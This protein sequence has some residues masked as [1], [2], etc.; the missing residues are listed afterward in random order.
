MTDP[1]DSWE[2]PELGTSQ[3]RL[4]AF[5]VGS[6]CATALVAF[7]VTLRAYRRFFA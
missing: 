7:A 6:Y 3:I 2:V 4:I 5:V 1:F